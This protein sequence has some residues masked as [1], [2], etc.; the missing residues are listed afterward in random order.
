[1]SAPLE[2][3]HVEA[4][5]A[6]AEELNFT[7]AA[8]RL[9]LTQ[10]TLSRQIEQAETLL[11]FLICDRDSRGVA[12][13]AAGK[14]VAEECRRAK[15]H[16]RLAQHRGLTAYEGTEHLLL[17]G[18]S[19]WIDHALLALVF[20]IKLPQFPR[21]KIELRSDVAPSLTRN[22]LEGEIHV[23]IMTEPAENEA[24][25]L[26]AL[27]NSPLHAVF[28]AEHP[29]AEKFGIGLVDFASDAWAILRE[30]A[31]PELY[32][33]F[34]EHARASRLRP[35]EFHQIMTPH[36]S[37]CLVAGR[38]A[39]SFLPAGFAEQVSIPGVVCRPLADDA[40][41]IATYT[42]LRRS[43]DS[44]LANAF[45]RGY[46]RRFNEAQSMPRTLFPL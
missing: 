9:N 21:L 33:R 38:L 43:D 45:V 22:L 5:V 6:L 42:A 4:I 36:E 28:P 13:T 37:A 17:V 11:G 12:F 15:H 25:I 16:L 14:I 30:S 34:Q 24:L 18:H 2:T 26:T 1:M 40:L 41:R 23:A 29:A 7:R 35:K 44:K 8:S 46:H 20:E 19:P 10:P 3:R 31:D 27:S 39:V 32:S